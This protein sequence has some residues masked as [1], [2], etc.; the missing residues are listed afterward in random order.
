MQADLLL[1]VHDAA[2][3]LVAEEAEDVRAVLSDLGMT[4]EEQAGTA[5][6]GPE[7]VG[8]S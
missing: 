1:H 8:P 7:Q 6:V 5:P 3:P 4:E 2:S